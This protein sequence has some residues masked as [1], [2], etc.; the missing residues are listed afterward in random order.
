MDRFLDL[1]VAG[2]ITPKTKEALLKQLNQETALVVPAL[3]PGVA[4]TSPAGSTMSTRTGERM[5]GDEMEA[6]P[7]NQRPQRQQLARAD[8][9]ITDPITKIVGLILGSPEFQRQ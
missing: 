9:T 4:T 1:I 2:D 5:S 8:A 3:A 7:F 6:P